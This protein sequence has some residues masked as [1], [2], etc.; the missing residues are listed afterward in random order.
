M[1][2]PLRDARHRRPELRTRRSDFGD[3]A[4]GNTRFQAAITPLGAVSA[5]ECLPYRRWQGSHIRLEVRSP[6]GS[7]RADRPKTQPSMQKT[8]QLPVQPALQHPATRPPGHKAGERNFHERLH[9]N[10][11]RMGSSASK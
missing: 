10:C 6:Q 3:L 4:Q 9:P 1:L 5:D 11:Q 2:V 7:L 8:L